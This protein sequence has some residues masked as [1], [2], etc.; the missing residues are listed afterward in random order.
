MDRWKKRYAPPGE[1]DGAETRVAARVRTNSTHSLPA[2][3]P[4]AKYH[5]WE[6][7]AIVLSGAAVY[8]H[9]Y[10]GFAI[11]RD[12]CFLTPLDPMEQAIFDGI[13]DAGF[14]PDLDDEDALGWAAEA[15]AYEAWD[16]EAKELSRHTAYTEVF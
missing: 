14:S 9:P 1:P 2:T 7:T 6:P 12:H 13:L 16:A 10:R 11:E 4:T 3:F 8:Q 5:G 15:R